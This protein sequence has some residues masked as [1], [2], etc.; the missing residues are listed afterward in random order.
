MFLRPVLRAVFVAHLRRQHVDDIHN[1]KSTS[2][3]PKF[4]ANFQLMESLGFWF[5]SHQNATNM[6]YVYLYTA[7][8]SE[9]VCRHCALIEQMHF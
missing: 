4:S 9:E 2:F 7:A 8:K 3:Q 6:Y 5:Q 1:Q